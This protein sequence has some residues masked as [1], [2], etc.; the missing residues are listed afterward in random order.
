MGNWELGID[1]GRSE[2]EGIGNGRSEAEGIGNCNCQ[3]STVPGQLSGVLS[4]EL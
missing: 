2:A 3:L 4:C 1:N